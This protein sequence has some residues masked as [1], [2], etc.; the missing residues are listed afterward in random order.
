MRRARSFPYA[1]AEPPSDLIVPVL[2]QLIAT[3]G[4]QSSPVEGLSITNVNFRDSSAVYEEQWE[5]PSGGDW[6]LHRS[7]AVFLQG[8][9]DA[10]ISGGVFKRLDGNAIMLNGYNRGCVIEKNEFVYIADNVLAGWGETKEWDG[11]NGDQPR[12]T[13]VRDNY[14]HELGFFEKQSS[15][16]FQALTATTTLENNIM[17]NMREPQP[18]DPLVSVWG[19]ERRAEISGLGPRAAVSWPWVPAWGSL[20]PPRRDGENAQKTGKTGKKWARYGL[21][22]VNQGS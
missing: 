11:R 22:S 15:A 9:K 21:R 10:H 6:A 17:F 8:T 19:V 2:Q 13:V 16:W 20:E 12:G 3:T 1:A 5:V 4:T 7:G 14:I 18:V